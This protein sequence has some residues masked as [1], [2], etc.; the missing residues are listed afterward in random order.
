MLCIDEVVA[1]LE[2]DGWVVNQTRMWLASHWTVRNDKGWLAGQEFPAEI[3][4][5]KLDRE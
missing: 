2:T 4:P 3:S 5:R 1:E